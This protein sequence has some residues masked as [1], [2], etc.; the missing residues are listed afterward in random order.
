MK[1]TVILTILIVLLGLLLAFYI[2]SENTRYYIQSTAKGVAYKIDRRTGR[3]WLIA[4][5]REVLVEGSESSV[6]SS[7]PVI[8]AIGLAKNSHAFG[9]Y[10]TVESQIK[11]W[12]ADKKGGLKIYGWEAKKVDDQKYLVS[13]TF[14]QGSGRVG[15]FF[16]VNLV[17][18]IVRK[19]IGDPELEKEYGIK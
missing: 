12:L 9:G 16:E 2:Y 1:K 8:R 13:Y 3:T 4:G 10:L 18:N 15:Y 14:D 7:S 11:D 6:Q 19:V 5:G 17:A